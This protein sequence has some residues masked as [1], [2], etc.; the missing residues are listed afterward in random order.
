[1]TQVLQGKNFH[2]FFLHFELLASN[3]IKNET[4]E[5][6]MNLLKIY[7]I[8]YSSKFL[9]QIKKHLGHTG[10]PANVQN[11]CIK[12]SGFGVDITKLFL[13]REIPRNISCREIFFN[14]KILSQVFRTNCYTSSIVSVVLVRAQ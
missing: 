14:P 6:F 5:K 7:L 2:K 1:M 4:K 13:H 9:A 8:K 3:P 12:L 10:T 11:N